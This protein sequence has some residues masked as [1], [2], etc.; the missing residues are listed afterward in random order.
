MR[1]SVRQYDD[2]FHEGRCFTVL[3][4]GMMVHNAVTADDRR[5]LVEVTDQ[6]A[7]TGEFFTHWLS[8][9]VTIIEHGFANVLN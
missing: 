3:L 9:K 7:D 1:V 5:G 8:G 6:D 4:D 2:G